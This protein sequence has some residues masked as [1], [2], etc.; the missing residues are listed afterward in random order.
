MKTAAQLMAPLFVAAVGSRED[1]V[2]E[3]VGAVGVAFLRRLLRGVVLHY[4]KQQACET[5]EETKHKM[6]VPLHVFEVI[7]LT[8]QLFDLLTNDGLGK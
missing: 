2:D 7:K 6:V 8:P 1:G 4:R 3:V 5:V